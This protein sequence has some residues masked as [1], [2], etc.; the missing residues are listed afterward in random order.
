MCAQPITAPRGHPNVF[1][2][3]GVRACPPVS[4][5]PR[6]HKQVYGRVNGSGGGKRQ[7]TASQ[8]ANFPKRSPRN[9]HQGVRPWG[10][11]VRSPSRNSRCTGQGGGWGSGA[12]EPPVRGGSGQT[13]SEPQGQRGRT[14]DRGY[15]RTADRRR[16]QPC[17]GGGRGPSLCPLPPPVT[18]Q[19]NHPEQAGERERLKARRVPNSR[20]RRLGIRS[21][22]PQTPAPGAPPRGGLCAC[23]AAGHVTP[24]PRPHGLLPRG[25]RRSS[26]ADDGAASPL[27][28]PA[29]RPVAVGACAREPYSVTPAQW[30]RVRTPSLWRW[31]R[32][33]ASIRYR[34]HPV[35]LKGTGQQRVPSTYPFLRQP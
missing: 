17:D 32:T 21:P 12:R 24:L 33:E 19:E 7:Q 14:E 10:T 28:P 29:P 31:K 27:A 30:V 25:V 2:R 4:A 8:E 11:G 16:G 3:L 35:G 9:G 20:K 23:A 6:R 15:N 13:G 26:L 22:A 18:H 1:R 34:V 5:A